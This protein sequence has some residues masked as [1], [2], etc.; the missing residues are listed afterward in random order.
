MRS[1]GVLAALVCALVAGCGGGEESQP[2]RNPV[3]VADFPDPFVLEVDGT[4]YAYATNGPRGNVQT[5]TSTDLVDWQPG[6]DALPQLGRWAY[7]GKT[8]A[9]EVLALENGTYVLYYTA[10][11][12]DFGRQCIGVAV[13]A[14]PEGPFV[15]ASE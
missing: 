13:A 5:L 3:H 10:N 12:A 9:P 8:W 2:F 6:K 1:R 14:Q 15:D 11:A 7:E 4:Y